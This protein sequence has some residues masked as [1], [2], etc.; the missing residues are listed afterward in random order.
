MA[1][2]AVARAET[3]QAR[4][5]AIVSPSEPVSI[6]HE[7][8]G[9]PYYRVLYEDLRRLGHVEGKTLIVDR[10][11][12]EN[13]AGG[14]EAMI[15]EVVR[16]KPDV[17]Y[18][19]GG[20][21][22]VKA[23]T[24]T[25]PVVVLTGDPIAL[26]LARSLARPGGNFTGVSVD[27]GPSLYGKRI[28]VL[29]EVFPRLSTLAYV[30]ARRAWDA[31]QGAPMRAAAEAARTGLIPA[32][33]DYPATEGDYRQAILAAHRQGADAIMVAD[34]PEALQYRAAIVSVLAEA[35]LPAIHT[36][37][38]SVVT[39]GLIAY[40]FDLKELNRQAAKDIDAILKGANPAEI[41]FY[42]VSRLLLSINLGTAKALGLTVPPAL[43][44]RADEVIE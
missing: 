21:P 38:E 19:I 31:F 26:G 16:S 43:L 11:G 24:S 29:R 18:A 37:P 23:A 13:T 8:G 36:F 22:L 25:I 15:A 30:G 1:A 7:N 17:I 14:V 40:S 34:S 33:V 9:N 4:R 32:L 28:E 3:A 10:F 35:R 42:Q 44:A 12:R 20:G 41:P 5:L 2:P 6:M 27:T 39:G